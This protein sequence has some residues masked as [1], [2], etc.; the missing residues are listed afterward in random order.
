M[1]NIE[2][3]DLQN[4]QLKDALIKARETL[5]AEVENKEIKKDVVEFRDPFSNLCQ[6]DINNRDSGLLERQYAWSNLAK[7]SE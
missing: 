2:K 7:D 3:L 5:R 1:T 6:S 4:L